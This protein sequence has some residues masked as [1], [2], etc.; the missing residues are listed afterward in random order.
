MKLPKNAISILFFWLTFVFIFP[1]L[2]AQT[3]ELERP[4]SRVGVYSVDT[5]VKESFD[6]YENVYKYD[7]YAEAG[8]LDCFTLSY[9]SE[10]KMGMKINFKITEWISESIAIVK[11][12]N[13]ITKMMNFW[14]TQNLQV[15][16]NKGY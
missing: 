3:K 10:I 11:K 5:F 6:I 13:L 4:K 7:G 9:D 15:L 14:D 8:T 1:N 12:A 16:K 2:E